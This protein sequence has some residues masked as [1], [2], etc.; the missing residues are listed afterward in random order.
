MVETSNPGRATA[1]SILPQFE[2][3]KSEVNVKINN[4]S[5]HL[6]DRFDDLSNKFDM[7][8]EKLTTSTIADKDPNID[9]TELNPSKPVSSYLYIFYNLS[10]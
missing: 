6:E 4:M 1:N 9:N 8:L 5:K 7:L 10:T 2:E 3:F